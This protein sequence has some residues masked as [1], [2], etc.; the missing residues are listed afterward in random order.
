LSGTQNIRRRDDRKPR[1]FGLGKSGRFYQRPE[2]EERSRFIGMCSAFSSFPS[3]PTWRSLLQYSTHANCPK[4]SSITQLGI[5]FKVDNIQSARYFGGRGVRFLG[6]P[7]L[8]APMEDQFVDG[9]LHDVDN[10]LLTP[11]SEVLT[12]RRPMSWL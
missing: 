2:I 10:N 3:Y 7:H 8:I 9:F 1:R 4:P 6:K 12:V 5:Y 11:M